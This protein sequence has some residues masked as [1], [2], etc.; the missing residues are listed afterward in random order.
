MKI[1]LIGGTGFVGRPLVR[2]LGLQG[3]EITVMTRGR[4]AWHDESGAVRLLKVNRKDNVRFAK[5]FAQESFDAIYDLAAY[6]PRDII[7]VGDTFTRPT[8]YIFVSSAAVYGTTNSRSIDENTP[9]APLDWHDYGRNKWLAEQE[10]RRFRQLD[11]VI[12]RPGVVYGPND[13]HEPRA[14][15]FFR[16]LYLGLPIAIPGRDDVANNYIYVDDL[17]ELL[18]GC[19]TMPPGTIINA[20]GEMF[21]WPQ[22]LDDLSHIMARRSPCVYLGM[23]LAEFR[24]WTLCQELAFHHN[25]FHDFVLDTARAQHF[26]WRPRHSLQQGLQATWQWLQW[27]RTQKLECDEVARERELALWQKI[28][29]VNTEKKKPNK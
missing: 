17:A 20:G 13:P 29:A 24:H 4:T 22:Y 8:R 19:L 7:T 14:S 1:L 25:A 28:D 3:H 11:T 16:K 2:M 21:T 18:C 12:V 27:Q 9:H 26:G 10:I 15:Y 6:T 23:S 5:S